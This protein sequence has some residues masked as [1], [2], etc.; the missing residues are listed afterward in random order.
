V[1]TS[2]VNTLGSDRASVRLG[3]AIRFGF[4]SVLLVRLRKLVRRKTY[5]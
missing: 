2:C 1:R 3:E 4:S 5:L